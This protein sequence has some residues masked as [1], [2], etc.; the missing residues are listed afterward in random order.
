M[1]RV[2][3][4]PVLDRKLTLRGDVTE[5]FGAGVSMGVS[6]IRGDEESLSFRSSNCFLVSARMS[7]GVGDGS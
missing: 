7:D 4:C 1:Y 2:R 6:V 3:C 5:I